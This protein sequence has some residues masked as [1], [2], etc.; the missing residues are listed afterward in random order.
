MVTFIQIECVQKTSGLVTGIYGTIAPQSSDGVPT[1][2]LLQAKDEARGPVFYKMSRTGKE[3][4]ME[5]RGGK[6][7]VKCFF[8]PYPDKKPGNFLDSFPE[9]EEM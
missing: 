4:L 7:G 5:F 9:C 3:L 2:G 8:L 6:D 1:K